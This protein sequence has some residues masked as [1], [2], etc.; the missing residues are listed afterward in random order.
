MKTL[1]NDL[2]E[3]QSDDSKIASINT[4][5]QKV[6]KPTNISEHFFTEHH[7]AN[8]ILVIPFGKKATVCNISTKKGSSFQNIGQNNT[9]VLPLFHHDPCFSSFLLV[10]VAIYLQ[11]KSDSKLKSSNTILN[12]FPR[13]I[14]SQK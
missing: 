5:D 4:T 14:G 7:T 8:D 2:Q 9:I 13:L 12:V 10:L 3:K 6:E 1:S 11:N